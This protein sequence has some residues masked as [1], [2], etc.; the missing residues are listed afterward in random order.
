MAITQEQFTQYLKEPV[1]FPEEFKDYLSD[2]FALNVPKLHVSQIF[3]FKLQ[4][5]QASDSGDITPVQTLSNT[6]SYSSFTTDGPTWANIP[7]GF[8]LLFFGA[9]YEFDN[10]G[11]WAPAYNGSLP[12]VWLTP[13]LDGNNLGDGYAAYLNA[14]SN[15]RAVLLDLTDPT[16]DR[17]TLTFQYKLSAATGT[18]MALEDRWAYLIKVV[19]E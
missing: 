8:Y 11:T 1:R 18:S 10:A 2:F 15:G 14:G 19:T 5:F 12:G 6:T 16:I 9:R 13:V 3:G 7:R 4:S 17:H